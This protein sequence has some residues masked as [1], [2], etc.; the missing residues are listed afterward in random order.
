[1][2]PNQDLGDGVDANDVPFLDRFP[3]LPTPHPGYDH[4]HAHANAAN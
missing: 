1:V 4:D 3:Y 2:S